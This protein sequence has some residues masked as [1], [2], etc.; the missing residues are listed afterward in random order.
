MTS[1]VEVDMNL[2]TSVQSE[3]APHRYAL[4]FGSTAGTYY[5]N[6]EFHACIDRGR[7]APRTR[8][9]LR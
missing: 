2:G 7:L 1:S 5:T 6:R 9:P 8:H 4:T 3:G